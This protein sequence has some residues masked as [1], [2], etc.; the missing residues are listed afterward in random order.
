MKQMKMQPTQNIGQNDIGRYNDDSSSSLLPES[1]TNRGANDILEHC[2]TIGHAIY[3]FESHIQSFET[4]QSRVLSDQASVTELD[5]ALSD[6]LSLHQKIKAQIKE[7]QRNP[8]SKAPGNSPQVGRLDRLLKSASDKVQVLQSNF[9]AHMREQQVRQYRI[10][11]PNA[12]EEEVKN[13]IEVPNTQIFQ[14][15]VCCYCQV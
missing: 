11:N 5:A 15:A 14:Q 1:G 6:L 7:I 9:R 3:E 10:V 13:A 2:R 8:E 4:L 12:T